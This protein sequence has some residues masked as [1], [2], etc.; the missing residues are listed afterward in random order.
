MAASGQIEVATDKFGLACGR[1]PARRCYE[2]RCRNG[3][4]RSDPARPSCGV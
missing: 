4:D 1:L 3:E 2:H